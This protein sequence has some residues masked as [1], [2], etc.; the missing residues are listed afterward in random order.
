MTQKPSQPGRAKTPG[1]TQTQA[2]MAS[3]DAAP[4]LTFGQQPEPETGRNWLPWASASAVVIVVLGLLFFFG[5]HGAATAP[6]ADSDAAQS[7][8]YAQYLELGQPNMSQAKNFVDNQV[9]YID[10][11]IT[12]HGTQTVTGVTVT[13]TFSSDGADQPQVETLPMLL[14]R[15]HEPYVDTE[16]ISAEPL[17]PGQSHEFRLIFDDI[18]PMWNQQVPHVEV[19]SVRLASADK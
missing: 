9:T 14:I 7:S 16:P 2:P 5:G 8:S 13:A 10:G 11:V 19:T 17:K 18:S 12:N 3:S 15:T 6:A 1:N 4:G